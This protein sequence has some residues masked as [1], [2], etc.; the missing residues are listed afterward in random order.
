MEENIPP[1]N[2]DFVLR[3][4]ADLTQELLPNSEVIL[5]NTTIS[6]SAAINIEK[7][8]ENGD[9]ESP[10]SIDDPR[11]PTKPDPMVVSAQMNGI[12]S[13]SSRKFRVLYEDMKK[14]L[15]GAKEGV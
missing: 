12:A 14:T 10:K 2:D 8:M 1:D 7:N 9:N 5:L 15:S 4:G 3:E 11:T 13:P 6:T